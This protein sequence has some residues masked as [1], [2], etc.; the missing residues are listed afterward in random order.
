MRRRKP[1]E[2]RF[3]AKVEQRGECWVWTG[4]RQYSGYG[5]FLGDDHR[6]TGAHQW[7]WRFFRGPVPAGLVLDH[8]CR[9]RSCVNPDHLE[10]VT[11]RINVRR[12]TETITHCPRG[13]EYTPEN[14]R[15]HRGQHGYQRGCRACAR[16]W[17]KAWRDAKKGV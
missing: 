12:H 2:E 5:R 16:G 11:Q 7:S 8:L 14:T 6:V 9:N 4:A 3:F 17:S 1:A 13:H 10:P 15:Q